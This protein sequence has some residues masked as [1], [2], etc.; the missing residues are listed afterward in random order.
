MGKATAA[1][2]A[3]V[4]KK[5][6]KELAEQG[7]VTASVRAVGRTQPW[8]YMCRRADPE[9]AADWDEAIARA[10][11]KIEAEIWRIAMEPQQVP[12]VSA[13]K[14]VRH[15]ESGEPLYH[16]EH[17]TKLLMFLAAAHMPEK[18]GAKRDVTVHADHR[19]V[20]S[21]QGSQLVQELLARVGD[22]PEAREA[23][24][25]T[26]LEFAKEQQRTVEALPPAGGVE[27][28]ARR[29]VRSAA[30]RA[31]PKRSQFDPVEVYDEDC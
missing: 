19:I 12:I 29:S 25:Q 31:P 21:L 28:E 9:F 1:I 14:H 4:K 13:G 3:A 18:Y 11:A 16:E 27:H 7:S 8:A 10:C 22:N 6:L 30:H 24:A 17:D 5:F 20:P 2:A 26:F 23:I 15:A